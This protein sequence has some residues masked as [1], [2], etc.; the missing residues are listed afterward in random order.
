[1]H[2]VER[3]DR[4]SRPEERLDWTIDP[5]GHDDGPMV[6]QVPAQMVVADTGGQQQPRRLH[7]SG[8]DHDDIGGDLQHRATPD[9]VGHDRHA[10]AIP[11]V[12]DQGRLRA[13]QQVAVAGGERARQERVVAAV[14][15][16]HRAGVADALR[17]TVRRPGGRRATRC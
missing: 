1:V 2:V 7:G 5:A 13:G 17:G 4:V 16:V 12:L 11:A 3:G 14:L 15:G 9:G 6:V 8:G 10:G